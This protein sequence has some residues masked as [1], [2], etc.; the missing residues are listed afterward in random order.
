MC[1]VPSFFFLFSYSFLSAENNSLSFWIDA[2]IIILPPLPHW[3]WSWTGT[4]TGLDWTGKVLTYGDLDAVVGKD[5]G[6]VG[7]SKL[8]GRHGGRGRDCWTRFGVVSKGIG[9]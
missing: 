7:N 2:P 4:W 1:H 3:T 5:Q 9:G 6:R 8:G